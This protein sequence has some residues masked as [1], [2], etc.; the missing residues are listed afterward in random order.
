MSHG[1][2]FLRAS[3]AVLHSLALNPSSLLLRGRI[4][5]PSLRIC[6]VSASLFAVRCSGSALREN[7]RGESTATM[8]I[9]PENSGENI[10]KRFL[11]FFATRGH[12][13]LPSS[14]LVPEDPTVLLTIAG[15]LQFKPIFLGQKARTVPRAT[16]SQ[17]CVRTNDIENVGVTA[18]HH[19]FF[20]MLGNF[21]FGDY[22]KKEAIRF[23]WELATKE[24]KLPEERVFVS[25]FEEDDEAFAIWRDEIGV[26]VERIKRMGAEDNF[27]ASGPTGPCGP[28]SEM[29]YDFHPER[30]L[31]DADLNDDSRFI[32][33]YNL[34]FMQSNRLDDGSLVPLQNK[35]I[36]TG[37]GLERMAQILQKVPNNYETDLI[38]PII[39]FA[40]EL[41]QIDYMKADERT[42]TYLKVIGDH[43]RAV[44]YLISDGVNPS[45]IGRGYI[46]RR[47]IRRVVR[48][49]RLLGI[50]GDGK[51]DLEGAF[52]PRIS[53]VA[54]NMSSAVDPFVQQNAS[55]IYEELYREEQRFVQT[56]ERGEKLLEKLLTDALS[57]KISNGTEEPK[58][59]GKDIFLL[60]DTFGFPVEITEEVARERGVGVDMDGFDKEMAVQKSQSQSAHNVVKLTVGG[61]VSE[62]SSTIAKS[63]FMGYHTTEAKGQ[64]VAL[65]TKGAPLTEASEG[66]E[67]ELILDETPFYAESGGQIG[68]HGTIKG[69]SEDGS[70][71]VVRVTD[72]QKAGQGLILHRGQVE[73]G[74][75]T[76][77]AKVEGTVDSQK[78][79]RAMAHHTATHLLQSALKKVLGASVSQAGSLVAFDRLRFDFNLPR[80]M[81]GEEVVN[82]ENL[83]NGWIGEAVDLET[84]VMALTD[85]KKSGA[86]AM[87]GEKYEDEVRVVNVEGISKELCG[88]THVRNT[89]DIR[90]IKIMSEQGI[91]AGVRRIE[92]V[93]GAAFIEYVNQRDSVVKQLNSLLKVKPEDLA[94]RVQA[95][96]DELKSMNK[97][98]A[99]LRAELAIAKAESFANNAEVVGPSNVRVLVT[100]LGTVDSDALRVAAEHLVAKMGDPSAFVIASTSADGKVNL[101]AAFSKSVVKQGLAAGKFL[102]PIAKLCGGG[103]G[104]K[105]N[106]AQAGG[107]L[108][109]K[110][111]EAL[112]K[113]KVDLVAALSKAS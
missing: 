100:S 30:G 80:A 55:R 84:K 10:R 14:S 86:I 38:Y 59:S 47:L 99:S 88:G 103:G 12:T 49:G 97:E 102:G 5:R 11:D 73:Q 108:P 57:G 56:L 71:F 113:A 66:Q 98:A 70:E 45:N 16:T 36:D 15:M 17:K 2:G 34:V 93:C 6:P 90:G 35:N 40:A 78:R 61:A 41:A 94:T 51:G 19:T 105:P 65:L 81:T 109:E 43:T 64:V 44:T 75:I 1:V 50:K 63:K 87:F 83:V 9:D 101:V 85:A 4:A 91:A 72:V 28:C 23:A 39:S 33:F 67:V 58:L 79:R 110:L 62:L 107:K 42:K 25:V 27:W 54:V 29:Y 24:Y 20:E 69:Q 52:L 89:A 68:D 48:M 106:F 112:N 53:E 26:P 92:A 96:Q 22:F 31:Q 3:S 46:V 77:G 104:G 111:E 13:I 82:V 37:L 7:L 8:A 32:E 60:Y 76:L 95:L 74:K 18:R 21:S